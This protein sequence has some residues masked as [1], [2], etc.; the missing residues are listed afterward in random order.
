[1]KSI[2][3]FG[4]SNTWGYNACHDERFAWN[5]RWT[6]TLQKL[7]GANYHIIEH[8][9]C[10][11][12]TRWNTKEEPWVN[13][14]KEVPRVVR[15]HAPIDLCIVMLGT[16]DIKEEY[17]AT[18]SDIVGGLEEVACSFQKEY[19]WNVALNQKPQILI[20]APPR[21]CNLRNSPFLKEFGIAAEAKSSQLAPGYKELARKHN[22]MFL[23]ADLV[24]KV[25]IYDG[26]HLDEKG[27]SLLA[28]AMYEHIK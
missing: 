1:M 25:G 7:L 4:D 18:I 16:N 26:I 27:H 3:C 8:G 2:L 11:R 6:G 21:I 5:V 15:E 9:V 14:L 22:W 23:D 10:G 19:M 13:G 28:K 20:V 12:T 24:T 17:Q